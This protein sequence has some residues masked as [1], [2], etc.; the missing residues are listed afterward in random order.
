MK[1]TRARYLM[2]VLAVAVAAAVGAAALAGDAKF[3]GRGGV[4]AVGSGV[5][6]VKG[7]GHVRFELHGSGRLVVLNRAASKIEAAGRGRRRVEGDSVVFEGYHGKVSVRGD[8]VNCRFEGGRVDFFG[9]G[10]GSVYLRGVGK[11]W[12]GRRGP[13]HWKKKGEHIAL[14]P[15]PE[16][17]GA[18]TEDETTHASDDDSVGVVNQI[19]HHTQFQEWAKTHPEAAAYLIRTK[20]FDRFLKNHP[21]AAAALLEHRRF[22]TWLKAHPKA[23]Q[24]VKRHRD[25][26][27]W[28]KAHPDLAKKHPNVAA[29]KSRADRND[30]GVVGPKERKIDRLIRRRKAARRKRL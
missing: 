10:R 26:A 8:R 14:K 5:V 30:D 12:K 4:R 24:T 28:A 20:D 7:D 29:W 9:R 11:Y 17:T 15:D 2:A 23:A 3:S 25:Y 6:H 19:V 22:I 16:T 21:K 27:K 18:V 13:F 1:A